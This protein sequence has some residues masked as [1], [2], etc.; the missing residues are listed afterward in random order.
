[1]DNSENLPVLLVIDDEPIILETFK[2]IFEGQCKVLTAQNGDEAL[3][4]I[5]KETVDLIFLDINIPGKNGLEILKKIKEHD[6]KI[7]VIIVTASE[8][9]E[10]L[11][12]AKRLGANDCINKPFDVEQ[13]I[14]LVNKS[15]R[16]KEPV[17]QA[18]L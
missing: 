2:A 12:E 13:V 16:G 7:A 18:T 9:W 14:M 4:C 11:E 10:K 15:I 8:S 1:M 3:A 5:G 17:K 6:K